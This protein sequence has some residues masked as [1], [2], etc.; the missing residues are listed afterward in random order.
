[1]ICIFVDQ[2][3]QENNVRC[4]IIGLSA[5]IRVCKKLCQATNGVCVCVCVCVRACNIY[6]DWCVYI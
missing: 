3:L 6:G 2:T 4:S 1:M 5:E